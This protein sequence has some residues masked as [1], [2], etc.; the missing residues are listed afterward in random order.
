MDFAQVLDLAKSHGWLA[1]AVLVVG[2]LVRLTAK[3]SRFFVS[4]PEQWQPVVVLGLGTLA[5]A[6]QE[7][8]GGKS[9]EH[10]VNASLIIAVGVLALKAHF[11]GREPS[12]FQWL[13]LVVPTKTTTSVVRGPG[14]MVIPVTSSGETT[15]E[16]TEPAPKKEST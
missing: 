12:W 10:A 15:V 8:V 16:V 14:T 2:F 6:L 13:A 5:D 7:V 1:I 4:V 9:W 11:H 3:D